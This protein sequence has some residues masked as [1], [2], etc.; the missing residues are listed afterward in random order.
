MRFFELLRMSGSSLWKR[1]LRSFLTI[2]GVVIG[3]ASIVVMVSLGLG[4]N[5]AT[6]QDIE[7]Y[8]GLT[9][10]TVSQ[11]FDGTMSDTKATDEPKLLNDELVETLKQIEHVESVYP[12]IQ[13]YIMAKSGAYEGQFQL[14]GR[15]IEA[16]KNMNLEFAQGGIP[17]EGEPLQLI[18]GN[19]VLLNFYTASNQSYS[20]WETG[21]LPD[22]DL[23]KDSI[24]YIL[25][26]DAYNMWKYG[27]GSGTPTAPPK[28][29][30]FQS[31]GVMA[32]GPEDYSE[33]G[34]SAYCDIDALKTQLQR[35]FKGKVI[36]GQPTT[37]SG[38]PYKEFYYNQV[39]VNCDSMENMKIVQQ[40]ISDLGYSAYSNAEWIEQT[41]K[42]TAYIQAALGGIGAISLLVAA[43]GI[44]NTMM[45]SIYERTKEIGIMKVLGCDMRNIQALF[46]MEAGYIG[47]IGG[48]VGLMLS[49]ILSAVINFFVKQ[50]GV[51]ET[52]ISYIPFWLGLASILFA[53]LVAI[54]AGYFPSRRA[55]KLSPLA[56]IRSE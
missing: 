41:K 21:E 13:T 51:M 4:L 3:V 31:A 23:M 43:I 29:Y 53:M 10:I 22:I 19:Q 34:W 12:V 26:T 50:S 15:P 48:V 46:L 16:L 27:D 55:M 40:T 25:D 6:M 37:K 45:M 39:Y 47:L 36:P 8:G 5:R 42:S 52:G 56:A 14:E 1:K 54:V 7:K 9:Q 33:Y 32:G 35:A 17:S 44:T 18:F 28:K 24:F 49:Y 11:N 2:L 30:L 20:Y 38:K